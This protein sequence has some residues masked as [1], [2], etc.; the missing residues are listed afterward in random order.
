MQRGLD[1]CALLPYSAS[2]YNKHE[3]GATMSEE[4]QVEIDR[5][6]REG[7]DAEV[8]MEISEEGEEGEEGEGTSGKKKLL[9]ILIPLILLVGG[10]AGVYFSG[11]LGGDD[12]DQEVVS[13]ES[14][15]HESADGEDA[16]TSVASPVF[17]E[18]PDI[19][20]NLSS[21]KQRKPRFLRLSVQ[22]D[23]SSEEDKAAVE[24]VMPRV[25][26]QFQTYLR[27]L[28]VEDLKGSAGIYRL[29]ME[30]LFRVNNAAHPVEVK[31]V[32]FQEILIQ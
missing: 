9:L 29:Q 17:L 3:N 30:L 10:G 27:E 25:I 18:I 21:E 26:D 15:E 6:P 28:R 4:D 22:L 1:L 8:D 13:E 19:V 16:A 2:K 24:A 12:P 23:L 5:S 31:D 20:V 7:E 32:L 14:G 11:I